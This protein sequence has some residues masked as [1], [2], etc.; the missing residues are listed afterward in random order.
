MVVVF[1]TAEICYNSY[2]QSHNYYSKDLVYRD[3]DRFVSI[4]YRTHMTTNVAW[5]WSWAQALE[6]I[7]CLYTTYVP[8]ARFTRLLMIF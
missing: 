8:Y 5:R 6:L 4:L 2:A 7:A 3:P 1:K